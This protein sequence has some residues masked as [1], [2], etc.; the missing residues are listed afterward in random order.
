[1]TKL[2]PRTLTIPRAPDLEIGEPGDIYLRRWWVIPRNKWFGVYLHHFLR[3]DDPRALHDHP[4]ANI[5]ILLRGSYRE[6][7]TGG[8]VKLRRPWRPI[9]RKAE[10]AHRIELIDGA[11]VWSLFLTGPIVR[12][13]GFHCKRGWVHWRDFV[14][15]RPG[16]NSIGQGCGE[17]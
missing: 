4:K 2:W 1:M 7:L 13:W 17:P 16:G 5:S 12:E 6:H 15:V 14:S 8:V 10:T 11:P 9:A 3:S